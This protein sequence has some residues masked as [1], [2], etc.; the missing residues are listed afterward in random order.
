MGD[1]VI[2]RKSNTVQ[3]LLLWR[4]NFKNAI[5][6]IVVS[7]STN[8]YIAICHPIKAKS[9]NSNKRTMIIIAS[10]WTL[11]FCVAIPFYFYSVSISS[12]LFSSYLSSIAA[13]AQIIKKY[14]CSI[15]SLHKCSFINIAARFVCN[16]EP[17]FF[18]LF[19]KKTK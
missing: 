2:N 4:I 5:L 10:L 15:D 12:V 6:M 1:N 13:F 19:H 18:I 8:R 9:I 17:P 3:K 7:L 16:V 14:T 11:S